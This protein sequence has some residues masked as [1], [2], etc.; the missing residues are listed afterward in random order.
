MPD[1]GAMIYETKTA[2]VLRRDLAGWQIANVAAFLAGGLAGTPSPPRW[3]S[4]TGTAPAA[5]TRR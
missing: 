3:A 2:L 4:P 5:P 1:M